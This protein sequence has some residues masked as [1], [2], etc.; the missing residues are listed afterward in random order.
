MPKF[1]Y[2]VM[3]LDPAKTALA[4]GR[5]LRISFKAA[6][7]ICAT[8]KGMK[9]LDAK[10][11]LEN[12]IAMKEMVPFKRFY[13]KQAHHADKLRRW[14]WFAGRY[15]VKAAKYILKVLENAEANAEDKGLDVS[16]LRIIHAAAQKGMKIKKYIPRAFGRSSPY[17]EQL[18]HV[19]IAVKEE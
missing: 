7:E 12:V 9:L 5:D 18:T 17:F 3:G 13:K 1:G 4:S 10:D 15:P 19:E 11:Y 6:R 2:S 16:K 14:R 8:I